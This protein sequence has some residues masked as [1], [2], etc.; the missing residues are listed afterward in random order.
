MKP[1][2]QREP[3]KRP[4]E[5]EAAPSL[6]EGD[7]LQGSQAGGHTGCGQ[8]RT[9]APVRRPLGGRTWPSHHCS[10]ARSPAAAAVFS[11]C[12]QKSKIGVLQLAPKSDSDLPPRVGKAQSSCPVRLRAGPGSERCPWSC[13]WAGVSWPVGPHP[14]PAG[15][16]WTPSL[17]P[18]SDR[19]SVRTPAD[20]GPWGQGCTDV[21]PAHTQALKEGPHLEKRWKHCVQSQALCQL[22]PSAFCLP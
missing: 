13:Q 8:G 19:W 11:H 12:H 22:L 15:R 21:T 9:P 17:H 14:G 1:V 5:G 4:R 3:P 6:E 7:P 18:M 16:C 10:V 20:P 2:K